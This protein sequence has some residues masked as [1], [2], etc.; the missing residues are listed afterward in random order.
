MVTSGFVGL[1]RCP[2]MDHVA[3]SVYHLQVIELVVGV[4]P[5][6]VMQM[7]L[8]IFH[9]RKSTHSAFSILVLEYFGTDVS[10]VTPVVPL[11]PVFPIPVIG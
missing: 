9:H 11:D 6:L 3:G 2:V 5:I 7:Y 10:C 4:V 1:Y 8:H